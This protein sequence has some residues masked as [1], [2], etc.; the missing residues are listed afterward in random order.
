MTS[1]MTSMLLVY[2]LLYGT[3][4]CKTTATLEHGV[5][6]QP[7]FQRTNPVGSSKSTCLLR[8]Q[9]VWTK[10]EVLL[11]GIQKSMQGWCYHHP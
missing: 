8:R 3:S 7:V 11:L 6:N 1:T 5:S 9:R 2:M 10:W 4:W